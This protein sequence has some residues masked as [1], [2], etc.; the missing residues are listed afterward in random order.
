M[1]TVDVREINEA[2]FNASNFESLMRG[3]QF[4]FGCPAFNLLT[5]GTQGFTSQ[6]FVWPC[7]K[8]VRSWFFFSLDFQAILIR[9]SVTGPQRISKSRGIMTVLIVVMF[10]LSTI[11]NAAYWAYVR[12]AFIAHG[13]T[14][15]ST[16]DAL[17]EYPVWFTG[18]TSVSDG[19]AVLADC[20]IVRTPYSFLLVT[21]GPY[22]T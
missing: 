15:Q 12:R 9:S 17:N 1:S 8:Y 18:I 16:A 7:P 11:H 14:S 2:Y 22:K 6:F 10:V 5:S 4:T 20:V 21:V 19:N 3:N 13:E